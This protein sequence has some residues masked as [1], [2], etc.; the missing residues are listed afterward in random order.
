VSAWQMNGLHG[1]DTI[2]ARITLPIT[3]PESISML[4]SLPKSPCFCLECLEGLLR[5]P[6]WQAGW[7]ARFSLI[8][9]NCEAVEP[10]ANADRAFC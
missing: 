7:Y 2:S 3:K 8:E 9:I 5:E 4:I 10:V 6:A 1:N